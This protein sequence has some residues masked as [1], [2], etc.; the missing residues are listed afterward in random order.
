MLWIFVC[1]EWGFFCLAHS[2]TVGQRY[3]VYWSP[4]GAAF[5]LDFCQKKDVRNRMF[6]AFAF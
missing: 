2:E 6:T 5:V 3:D 4:E 1:P